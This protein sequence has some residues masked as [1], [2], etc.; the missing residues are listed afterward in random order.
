MPKVKAPKFSRPNVLKK[1][2]AANLLAF[3]GPYR[4]YLTRRGFAWPESEAALDRNALTKVLA[5]PHPDIPPD[6]VD[7]LELVDLLG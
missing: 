4:D 5:A 1:V 6:L 2:Q 7:H 3:L